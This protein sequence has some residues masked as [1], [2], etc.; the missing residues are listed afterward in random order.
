[1]IENN[2]K[3]ALV[4]TAVVLVCF[5]AISYV[6]RL[7]SRQIIE[8]IVEK[9]EAALSLVLPGFTVGAAR[10]TDIDGKEFLYWEGEKMIDDKTVKGYA[11]MTKSPGYGGLVES[12]VGVDERGTILGLSIVNQSETPG[13]GERCVEVMN[14]GTL[15][16]YIRG[17]IPVRDFSDETRIP[18][19]QSQFKGLDA[20]SKI[21]MLKRG[22]WNP[23]MREYFLQKNAISALTGA[24]ATSS[25]VIMSIEEGIS[26]LKKARLHAAANKEGVK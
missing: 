22:D 12:M 6:Q 18:W 17:G 2:I 19:F 23:G 16:D 14:R 1:M 15:W 10:K 21:R 8:R 3:P 9:Q 13:L 7:T 24:T 11:F 25:A 5:L 26:R 20:N 4:L